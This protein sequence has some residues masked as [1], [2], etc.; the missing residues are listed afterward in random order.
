MSII[1]E[2]MNAPQ[3]SALRTRRPIVQ[4]CTSVRIETPCPRM[5]ATERLMPYPS[6]P[7]QLST[8]PAS[9]TRP[10]EPDSVQ[11]RPQV[12]RQSIMNSLRGAQHD[13]NVATRVSLST[14][15]RST[16]TGSLPSDWMAMC[17]KNPSRA[18]WFDFVPL[19]DADAMRTPSGVN[20]FDT[21]SSA[22]WTLM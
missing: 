5:F 16:G 15:L 20:S 4:P 17:P 19:F 13:E 2:S 9:L 21:S 7:V 18:E 6:S 11:P 8:P 14:L 10:M 3:T 12:S 1:A 22:A